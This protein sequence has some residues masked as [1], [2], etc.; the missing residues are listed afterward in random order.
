MMNEQPTQQETRPTTP[1]PSSGR[2]QVLATEHWSLLATRSLTY[3]ESFSRVSMFLTVLT[4]AVVALAL[5]AQVD[6]FHETFLMAAILILTVVV[7]VGLVTMGRVNT[8]NRENFQLVAGMNRLRHAYLEAYPD[9]EPYFVAASHDDL[10]G[11]AL[12]MNLPDLSKPSSPITLAEG[13]QS[14]PAMVRII[15]CVLAGLL[16]ALIAAA[17]GASTTISVVVAAV[18]FTLSNVLLAVAVQRAFF[19]YVRTAPARFPSPDRGA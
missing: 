11:F 5:F 4:G 13:F 15:V 6:H 14:L 1:E 17:F 7:F 19:K 2:L 3:M 9:V 16:G 12:T 18:I 8:L 10:R